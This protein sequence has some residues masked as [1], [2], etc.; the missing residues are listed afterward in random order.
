VSEQNKPTT[1]GEVAT[2]YI[3]WIKINRTERFW[4]PQERVLREDVIP[5]IGD[6]PLSHLGDHL[7]PLIQSTL[8]LPPGKQSRALNAT[9]ALVSW[10]I[11]Y[12]PH[13]LVKRF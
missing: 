11:K 5:A 1:F 8:T 10:S 13:L 12:V 6:L 7:Q 4:K 2:E 9:S 3:E